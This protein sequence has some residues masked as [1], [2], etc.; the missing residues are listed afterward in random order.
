MNLEAGNEGGEGVSGICEVVPDWL[1][2]SDTE[3]WVCVAGDLL[4]GEW[5][6][7]GEFAGWCQIGFIARILR[8]GLCSG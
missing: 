1:H 8:G 6:W 2:S 5:K 3:D 7:L 4:T